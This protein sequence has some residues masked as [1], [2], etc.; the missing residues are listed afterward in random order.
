[1]P[2]IAL[3][4]FRPQSPAVASAAR[5]GPTKAVVT[6][7]LALGLSNGNTYAEAL[8]VVAALGLLV[9]GRGPVL[10]LTGRLMLPMLALIV[11]GAVVTAFTGSFGWD[12]LRS[13][14]Y[15]LRLPILLG[16][17]IAIV[18]Y[19]RDIRVPLNALMLASVGLSL[20]FLFLYVTSP[21]IV[22]QGRYAVRTEIAGGWVILPLGAA[23]AIYAFAT[24]TRQTLAGFAILALVVLLALATIILSQSRT[25]LLAM[26]LVL[27][28]MLG[29]VPT[30]FYA[31]GIVPLLFL[32]LF[33]LT[34][35]VLSMLFSLDLV[36]LFDFTA[37]DVV[38]EILAL[39]RT[40]RGEM[41]VFWRGYEA[42]TAFDFVRQGGP[43]DMAV[44]T[45]LHSRVPLRD[46]HMLQGDVYDSIPTFHSL[47][48]FS[49]VRGGLL[50]VLLV[51]L[52]HV[53]LAVPLQKL[54]QSADRRFRLLGRFGCGVHLALLISVPTTAGL[55][56]QGEGGST[57]LVVLGLI[58]GCSALLAQLDT[59]AARNA[60]RSRKLTPREQRSPS[61]L[62]TVSY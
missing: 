56:N 4:S 41:N 46:L 42:F 18:V 38:R 22:A 20:Y 9:L 28:F 53:A 24:Q 27:I 5:D 2:S 36:N 6:V 57:P 10:A 45:G 52:Q 39:D 7:L 58:I 17:G 30:R 44:G 26:G 14:Y 15:V 60:G 50:G 32:F 49:L 19:F 34:T 35:P 12:A 11:L 47:Y 59:A 3:T 31:L 37:P 21:D 62:K 51:G 55:L 25:A 1:M 61:E 33:L 13:T 8:T 54:A 48:S 43:W 23:A 29:A 16:L 40:D